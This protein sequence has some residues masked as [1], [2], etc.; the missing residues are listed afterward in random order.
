[1]GEVCDYP[2]FACTCA[3]NGMTRDGGTRDG[4]M[5]VRVRPDA[6]GGVVDANACPRVAPGNGTL[7]P[8]AGEVCP[9]ARETCTCTM[10]MGGGMRDRW[11]CRAGD[12][13]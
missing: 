8:T 7:C 1:M 3:P 10:V 9:Y 13:G 5:C 2:G 11:V 12:G 6:G 4:W